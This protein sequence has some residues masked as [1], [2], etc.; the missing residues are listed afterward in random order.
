MID[1]NNFELNN[2]KECWKEIGNSLKKYNC[3]LFGFA[4][5]YDDDYDYWYQIETKNIYL[6]SKEFISRV[7]EFEQREKE[8][9]IENYNQ[10]CRDKYNELISKYEKYKDLE[11][12]KIGNHNY[13][14]FE[15]LSFNKNKVKKGLFGW[16]PNKFWIILNYDRLR[17]ATSLIYD[18]FCD[19]GG[20][21]GKP[22]FHCFHWNKFN[23]ERTK[24]CDWFEYKKNIDVA[25]YQDMINICKIID[26]LK[27]VGVIQQAPK[28]I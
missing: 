8:E 5:D 25:T 9:A 10:L 15:G 19:W 27:G 13:F 4:N 14:W 23:D 21:K 22:H 26:D 7:K 24:D 16:N 12:Y 6:E 1:K 18:D 11:P 17:H 28:K 20:S 3:S 2:E